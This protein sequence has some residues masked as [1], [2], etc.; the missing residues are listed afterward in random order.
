MQLYGQRNQPRKSE[1]KTKKHENNTQRKRRNEKKRNKWQKIENKGKSPFGETHEKEIKH[2][3]YCQWKSLLV[4]IRRT[5]KNM[6][7]TGRSETHHNRT[8][9]TFSDRSYNH[10]ICE[11]NHCSINIVIV[12]IVVDITVII[13]IIHVHLVLVIN[14]HQQHIY[15]YCSSLS[16]FIHLPISSLK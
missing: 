3:E 12:I 8:E 1:H 10:C 14:M 6:Y 7:I 15:Q 5:V 11:I 9:N 13:I 2:T 16:I 4:I